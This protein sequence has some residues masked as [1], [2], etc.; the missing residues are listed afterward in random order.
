MQ[1]ATHPRPVRSAAPARHELRRELPRA[2]AFVQRILPP[3]TLLRHRVRALQASMAAIAPDGSVFATAVPPGG[4][5]T[6][7]EEKRSYRRVQLPNGLVALLVHD[8][9]MAAH[10]RAVSLCGLL[11]SC[12]S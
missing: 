2:E 12:G 8:P 1:R 3:A 11:S 5:L 6:S 10:E 7:P 4:L 9:F